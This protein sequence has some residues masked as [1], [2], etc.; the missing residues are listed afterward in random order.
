MTTKL[1]LIACLV[2]ALPMTM[3]IRA[4]AQA[5]LTGADLKVTIP[6]DFYA[7]DQSLPAGVY[8]VKSDSAHAVILL[9]SEKIPGQFVTTNR[10]E[11][12]NTPGRGQLKFKRFGN[13]YFLEEVWVAQRGEGQQIRSGKLEKELVSKGQAVEMV[14]VQPHS[15]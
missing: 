7:G 14:M 13:N 12:I 6:F 3:A 10:L 5:N 4:S 2:L 15:H 8:T 1:R 9:C 11:T